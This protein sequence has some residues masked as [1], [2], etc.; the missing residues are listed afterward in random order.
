M[1][2]ELVVL[3]PFRQLFKRE[4]NSACLADPRRA[5]RR[6]WAEGISPPLFERRRR[7]LGRRKSKTGSRCHR[8]LEEEEEEEKDGK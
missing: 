1:E 6:P 8:D 7:W 4:K 5:V 3:M 2:N